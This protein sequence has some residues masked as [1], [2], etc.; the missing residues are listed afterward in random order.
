MIQKIH[1]ICTKVYDTQQYFIIIFSRNARHGRRRR[2][3]L[4]SKNKNKKIEGK[5]IMDET[6]MQMM[7]FFHFTTFISYTK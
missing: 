4:A 7:H 5:K 3:S 1:Q 6:L 2:R